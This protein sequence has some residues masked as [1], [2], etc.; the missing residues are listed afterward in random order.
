M[1]KHMD[2]SLRYT[3]YGI[4]TTFLLLFWATY[5]TLKI[6]FTDHEGVMNK[7]YYEIGLN[8]EKFIEE[9]K[10]LMEEGYHFEGNLFGEHPTLKSGDNKFSIGFFRGDV[11]IEDAKISL[12]LEKRATDKYTKVLV[13]PATSKGIYE[14]F[15][16]LNMEGKWFL[17]VT[18]DDHGKILKKY[19]PID[20]I[21]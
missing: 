15:T 1:F 17:T 18:G 6:A 9:Q 2:K 21:N 5:H 12:K 19:F 10:K 13:L 7:D 8:Y 20:V 4:I 3:F 14:G 11:P 16:N